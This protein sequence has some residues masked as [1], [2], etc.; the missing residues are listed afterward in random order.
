MRSFPQ[1]FENWENYYNYC[2]ESEN[3]EFERNVIIGTKVS[4]IVFKTNNW[5]YLHHLVSIMFI[6]IR[7]VNFRGF[8]ESITYL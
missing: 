6:I 4:K 7:T 3:N 5:Q 2:T 1:F 8:T